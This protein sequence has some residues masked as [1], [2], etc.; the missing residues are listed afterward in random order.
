MS[1]E[2]KA[3]SKSA[4]DSADD[5][6]WKLLEKT[7]LAGVQEQRRSRRWGI[8]F[9]LLTFV[10]LL[11]AL[12]LFTP[13][14]DMEKTAT[15]GAGYTALIEVTGMIADK[16]S[17][18]A[19]NIVTGL[20]AAFEDTKV[21]GIV[22]RINSPGGSPVQSGYVYDEIRRLR[23]LHPDIKV[24]AVISDLG[25]SGAYYIASA[26]D[27][28]YAD[29]ASLVGSIGVTAAGYGFVGTMEKLGVERRT[30]TSGEHKSFLDPFQPQKPEETQFWQGVLDTTHRQ[31]IASVKQ[32]RGERLKDKEHPELFSGLVWSGEQAL[33]LGLIDGLGN[34]SSVA[35]DVIGEK[36]LVD[37]TV[38]ESP[39]DRFSRKLGASVAEHLAMWM[40]FQGPTLR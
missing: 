22:L 34:A 17:A 14:M 21:K 20:R 31:F 30:Y 33:Q 24:Y 26:A 10:Y 28:I 36:E 19:D 15:R 25:A 11:V 3:P 6:S 12:A 37:F 18:S 1:D 29:K 40:G 23:G 4:A 8:F 32:G 35:R 38:Q 16:E 39:F 27:Q 13:L 2:W 7:L 9:K 5:K